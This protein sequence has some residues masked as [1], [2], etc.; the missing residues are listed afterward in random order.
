MR[1]WPWLEGIETALALRLALKCRVWACISAH[2][3]ESVVLPEK[4]QSVLIGADNDHNGRG[5]LAAA[6]LRRR[7]EKEGRK[8]RVIIPDQ[9]GDDWLNVLAR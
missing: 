2:G 7:M 4:V 8:V 3:L 9:V 5:Q 6:R 1:S